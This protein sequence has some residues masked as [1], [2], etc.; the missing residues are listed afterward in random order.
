MR[1]FRRID[2]GVGLLGLEIFEDGV[3]PGDAERRT[4][5]EE[6][7]GRFDELA[8]IDGNVAA[9]LLDRLSDDAAV[10]EHHE[11]GI[12]RDV[13]AVGKPAAMSSA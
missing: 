2:T 6:A 12:D 1:R 10:I 13:A 11:L 9:V 3:P 8:S 7:V 4:G 5:R